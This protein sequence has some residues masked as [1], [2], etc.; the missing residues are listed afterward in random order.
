[1]AERPENRI[2]SC[3]IRRMR[4][5]S[6]IGRAALVAP[7]EDLEEELGAS[8]GEWHRA[9]FVDDE[10]LDGGELGLEFKQTLFVTRLLQLMDDPNRRRKGDGKAAL[11][12][13]PGGRSSTASSIAA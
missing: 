6:G 1:M 9:E 3:R 12:K 5:Q 13:P 2:H 4:S 11:A 8:L 10:E 7:A